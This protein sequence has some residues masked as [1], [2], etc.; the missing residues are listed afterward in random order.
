MSKVSDISDKWGYIDINGKEVIP[1]IYESAEN[2]SN[3]K[4]SVTK[5]G[6]SFCIDKTGKTVDCE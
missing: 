2:F 6:V 3:G 1:C 5:D 4:A